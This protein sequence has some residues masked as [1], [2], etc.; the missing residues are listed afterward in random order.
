MYRRIEIIHE[1]I[2]S[3]KED[4][5]L[6]VFPAFKGGICGTTTEEVSDTWVHRLP[7]PKPSIHRNARFYFTEIGWDEI[8]RDVI[9]A[10]QRTGQ[11][12]RV[13]AIKENALDIIFQDEFQVAGQ[14]IRRSRKDGYRRRPAR[15]DFESA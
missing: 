4:G 6:L 10:C 8:G 15:R 13:L 11:R 9:A 5:S 1:S 12:Y 14:P 2:L 3:A 7:S